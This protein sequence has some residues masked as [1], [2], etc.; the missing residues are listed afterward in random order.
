MRKREVPAGRLGTAQE[1]ALFAVF[2]ASSEVNFI[3]AQ[4]I[5]FSGGW[6]V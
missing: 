3:A 4:G 6:A 5:A 1:D 2:L